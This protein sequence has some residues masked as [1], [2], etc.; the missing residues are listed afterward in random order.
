MSN[1]KENIDDDLESKE[2]VKDDL[3]EVSNKEDMGNS[4][5]ANE[6]LEKKG[7]S[8]SLALTLLASTLDQIFCSGIS[9]IILF[10]FNLILQIL[11][12]R[13]VL[14]GKYA[15]FIII[16]II[17]NILYYPVIHRTKL[18]NTIGKSLLKF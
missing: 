6:V 13:L 3:G 14:I 7:K 1:N 5:E 11:G 15:S 8:P 9:I 4:K 16:Y 12:Y 10:I 2:I 17:I 18:N